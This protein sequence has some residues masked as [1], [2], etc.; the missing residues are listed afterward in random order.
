MGRESQEN[1]KERL[2]AEP[3]QDITL[4]SS[5]GSSTPNKRGKGDPQ[6]SADQPTFNR[7]LRWNGR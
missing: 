3:S 4:R 7:I 1:V 5:A 6:L 2:D